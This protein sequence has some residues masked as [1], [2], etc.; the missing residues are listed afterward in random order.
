MTKTEAIYELLNAF[1]YNVD[2]S[3]MDACDMAIKAL[4]STMSQERVNHESTNDLISRADAITA[5]CNR[6]DEKCDS[7]KG[8]WLYTDEFIE[9]IQALPS[10]E[11]LKVVR[12]K[13]CQ[14]YE[15]YETWSACTYWSADPYEQ[16][17]VIDED[18]CSYGERIE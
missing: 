8:E 9:V 13:D 11:A 18:F 15:K 2:K 3:F 10:A 14:H 17:T 5:L 1:K 16:A 6:V 12:C 4:Q 7:N